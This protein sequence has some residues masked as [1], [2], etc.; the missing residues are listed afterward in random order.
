MYTILH[1]L[2]HW[3]V[4]QLG[5]LPVGLMRNPLE[6][7]GS[8]SFQQAGFECGSEAQAVLETGMKGTLL[9]H[10]TKKFLLPHVPI[11]VN[12][13]TSSYFSTLN[14]CSTKKA[15]SPNTGQSAFCVDAKLY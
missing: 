11:H 3:R 15:Q 12:I 13:G 5:V 8:L 6:I 2:F 4:H 7:T 10:N 14:I 9:K 1:F